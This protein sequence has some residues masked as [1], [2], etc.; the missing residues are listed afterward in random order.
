[1]KIEGSFT[2]GTQQVEESGR[3]GPDRVRILP[4]INKNTPEEGLYFVKFSS[5][6]GQ[7]F[8]VTPSYDTD[9]RTPSEL[10]EMKYIK[11]EQAMELIRNAELHIPEFE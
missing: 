5:E 7:Q 1:M 6:R 10:Q 3:P 11:E 9:Y 4:P 8:I 2:N